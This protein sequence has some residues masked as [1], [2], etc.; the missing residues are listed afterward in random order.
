MQFPAKACCGALL[1]LS[2]VPA[3]ASAQG[4]P[5]GPL[6]VSGGINVVSDY[7]FRGISQS[8]E[9]VE[10]QSTVTVSHISGLYAGAWG[11]G[12]PDSP[13]Y[14]QY[15][16][17]LYGGYAA[18]I[19]PGTSIDLGATYYVYPG[20]RD[21]AGP[22]DY[23]EAAGRLSHDLGPVSATAMLAYA[24]KQKSLG[25]DDNLYLNLDLSSGIPNSPV[26]LTASV[27]YT[28]GALGTAATNGHYL[29]WSLGARIIHGPVTLSARY[30]DTD[31]RKTGVKAV[32]T[33]YD[34]TLVFGIGLLF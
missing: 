5:S 19:A 14:G 29:D 21:R 32:D 10:L 15:E 31:I 17:D 13:R 8:E 16:L 27:G 34:P 9:K 1:A 7:R 28:D 11:S 30:V 12:L 33:L 6:S 20:N 23:V 18:E 26:T 24:P 25:D 2:F 3:A 4:V 22:S